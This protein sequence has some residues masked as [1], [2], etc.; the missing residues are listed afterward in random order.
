MKPE[1]LK[2]AV[3]GCD[4]VLHVASPLPAESPKDEDE[5]IKPAVQGT[6]GILEACVGS[7]VKKLVITSSCVA[8]FDYMKGERVVDEN[9]W[10]EITKSTTPYFK[11]KIL[12]EK[13]AWNF[14][15]NLSDSDKTFELSTVNPGLVVGPLLTKAEG[16]SQSIVTKIL[17]GGFPRLPVAYFPCVDVRDVADA[18]I[19][20]LK[21]ESGMRYALTEDT[22]KMADLG[23]F[24]SDEFKP[25][26]YKVTTKELWK[27]A[28]WALSFAVADMKAFWSGWNIRVHV[29]NDRAKEKLGMEF[30]SIKDSLIDMCY[31]LIK[32]GFVEDRVNKE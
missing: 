10:A 29:K 28:A 31:S 17:T 15:D 9:D 18:H 14:Y 11:S 2:E 24:I 4:Y 26:G 20:A 16:S 21:A 19:K 7:T 12:A 6:V 8:I 5:V 1:S 22:Y 30:I 32:H 23:R 13:E 25:Y 27:V 3:E